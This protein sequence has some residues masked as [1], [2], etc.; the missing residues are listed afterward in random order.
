MNPREGP[1]VAPKQSVEPSNE[2]Q[3]SAADEKS[4]DRGPVENSEE[5]LQLFTALTA[6]I[7]DSTPY[8]VQRLYALLRDHDL[9]AEWRGICLAMWSRLEN[10]S[11]LERIGVSE[12]AYESDVGLVLGMAEKLIELREGNGLWEGAR[13][14]SWEVVYPVAASTATMRVPSRRVSVLSATPESRA[15]R[16]LF[17]ATSS[18]HAPRPIR[19]SSCSS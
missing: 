7:G 10:R 2:Q 11:T 6:Y 16:P 5:E 13:G 15:K 17:G 12:P 14:D 4:V 1:P 18:K 8:I 3:A 9:E 19:R